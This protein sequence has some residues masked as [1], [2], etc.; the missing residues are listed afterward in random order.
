VTEHVTH[1][2]T[3]TEDDLVVSAGA[4]TYEGR[5]YIP[6]YG[7]KSFTRITVESHHTP[8]LRHSQPPYGNS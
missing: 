2:E 5:V 7:R 4:L 1:D 3:T 6:D 8:L